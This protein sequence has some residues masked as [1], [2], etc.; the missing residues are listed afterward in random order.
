MLHHQ[1]NEAVHLAEVG[2]GDDV[3]VI[4]AIHRPR[5]TEEALAVIGVQAQVLAEDLDRAEAVDHHVT[6]EVHARHAAR[7]EPL[8]EPEAAGDGATQV[9]V[10]RLGERRPVER[11]KRRV[12]GERF[13][14]PRADAHRVGGSVADGSARGE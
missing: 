14:A 2:D 8:N 12:V 4:D 1:E 11:T 5:F 7:A 13:G 9:R 3:G 6:R 10:G